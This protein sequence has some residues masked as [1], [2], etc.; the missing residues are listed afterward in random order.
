MDALECID[1]F[2]VEIDKAQNL[3][4]VHI[5]LRAEIERL[6]FQE[7]SYQLLWPPEGPRR[8]LYVTNYPTG[9]TERY[10]EE[11]HISHDLVSRNSA[12]T[13]L[14]FLWKDI[15]NLRNMTDRQRIVFNE[16]A[17]F[18][19]H[20]N[21]GTIP[22]HGPGRA[23]A[24]FAVRNDMSDDEFAKLFMTRRHELHLLATYA[25]ERLLKIG[26]FDTPAPSLKL[27]PREIEVLTWS[28]RGK[29]SLDIG[30]ILSITENTV[31]EHI[32]NACKKMGV[33]NRVHAAV[34]AVMH[35]LILP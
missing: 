26:L 8:P 24:L 33:S 18:G 6:G 17:E 21:G 23:R 28:A 30:D 10:I 2:I 11:Q 19:G 31:N 20:R 14:P 15:P 16:S 27:T 7:F 12:K 32:D 1:R 13:K 3:P 35:G 29:T 9:W 5:I 25:H 34:T 22:I 4:E